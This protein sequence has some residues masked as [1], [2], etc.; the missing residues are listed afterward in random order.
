MTG[1]RH[2]VQVSVAPRFRR[3]LPTPL[4]RHWAQRSLA[5]LQQ[6]SGVSLEVAV[7]GDEEVQALN[8][9]YRGLDEPTDVLSFSYSNSGFP[10]AYPGEGAVP[11]GQNDAPF[12]LPDD[13]KTL[14][15]EIVIA[16]PYA[17]R[18]ALAGGHS[19]QQETGLLLVHGVLHLLG[20]DHEEPGDRRVMWDKTIE[21]LAGLG[22]QPPPS[23]ML[24]F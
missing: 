23:F 16:L 14:L 6:P 20:F 4:V 9:A 5:V 12:V 17:E 24:S 3:A 8:R 2:Q 15:G 10:G 7:T 22:I 1:P 19:L 21:L 18:Q 13:G 11:T